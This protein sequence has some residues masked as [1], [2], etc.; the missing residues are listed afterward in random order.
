MKLLKLNDTI[1]YQLI[2]QKVQK[3]KNKLFAVLLNF[4]DTWILSTLKKDINDI[5]W[6]MQQIIDFYMLI[7]I[8]TYLLS[9]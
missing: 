3:S 6:N 1:P 7:L 2:L 4:W 8:L 5:F 9:I